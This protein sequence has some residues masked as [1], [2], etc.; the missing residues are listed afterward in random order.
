MAVGINVNGGYNQVDTL[1]SP[2]SLNGQFSPE[3]AAEEQALN[4]RQQLANLLMQRGLQS[5]Q[6]QMAGRFYVAPSWAQG[7]SQ[8]GSALAGA[9]LGKANDTDRQGL[10]EKQKSLTASAI[11]SY[12]DRLSPKTVEQ[13]AQGPGAPVPE[14]QYLELQPAQGPGA[15]E[16][17]TLGQQLRADQRLTD[18]SPATSPDLWSRD[19]YRGMAERSSPYYQEG[20]KPSYWEL[21]PINYQEGP[22]PTTPVVQHPTEGDKRKALVEAMTSGIPG[23]K[24]FAFLQ[25]K[26]EADAQEKVA[27]REF[28]SQEKALD[29]ENRLAVVEGQLNQAMMMGL[30][31]KDQKDQMLAMQEQGQANTAAHQKEME[32]IQRGELGVKQQQ[33]EQGKTPTGYR[34][35][36][37]GNLEPIPGGPADTK[38]Q[39]VLNQ[40]TAM[41]QNSNAGFDRLATTANEI[42]NHPGLTGIT[43][44]RGKVPDVPGTDAANARALLNTL[45]SQ[46]GFGVLQEMRNNSKTGGALGAVSDAEGKRLENNLAALDTTQDIGQFKKQL[47]AIVDYATGAKD[48]LRD[49]FNMK[50]KTGEPK[51]MMPS[52]KGPAVGTVEGGYRYKGGDPAKAESWEQVQ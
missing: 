52:G 23:L 45:K 49:A 32:R 27:Q 26:Q 35:S 3:I 24:E 2:Y 51:P 38:L 33:V 1:S 19:E 17:T 42:L 43:G 9:S 10:A 47:Q 6:G 29:R 16:L 22:Q 5:P 4:R 36:L 18:S 44:I 21:G 14:S 40:D 50:H 31:T 20:V 12:M 37:D 7:V 28:L 46:V 15:P 41:L 30:I 8:L 34:R 13:P 11:Q 39:G 48:R 25:A